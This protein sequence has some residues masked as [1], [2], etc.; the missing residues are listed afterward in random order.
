ML[1]SRTLE[2]PTH[3]AK[4]MMTGQ[5]LVQRHTRSVDFPPPCESAASQYR[6]GLLRFESGCVLVFHGGVSGCS[7]R[8]NGKPSSPVLRGLGA[9]NDARLLDSNPDRDMRAGNDKSACSAFL[10]TYLV[11]LPTTRLPARSNFWLALSPGQGAIHLS[12][13]S[14]S[15]MQECT[16]TAFRFDG[17]RVYAR[18][19]GGS[20]L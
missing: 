14:I 1:N 2:E 9:S 12:L 4:Q 11:R 13:N 20:G 16:M 8:M 19:S 15:A 6:L 17:G 3:D 5:P 7:C 10:G 18:S